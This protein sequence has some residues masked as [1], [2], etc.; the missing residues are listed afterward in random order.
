LPD[1][2]IAALSGTTIII[3]GIPTVVGDFNAATISITDAAGAVASST[4][5]ININA[6]PTI[7]ALTTT[8]WTVGKSGFTGTMTVNNGT[9]PTTIVGN[10]VGLP[11]G[12]TVQLVGNTLSFTG[13]P[14]EAGKYNGVVTIMDA[15]GATVSRSFT[16]TINPS[17]TFSKTAL[18]TYIVNDAY[19]QTVTA[20]GGT[21]KLK[22]SITFSKPLPPGLKLQLSPNGT[23]YTISGIPKALASITITIRAIDSVGAE[24][25]M[26]YT[27]TGAQNPRRRA[28]N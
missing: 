12:V 5:D 3:S 2:L 14:T 4:Y 15:A 9:L 17:I 16:I 11:T 6:A 21:G 7:T 22:L 18:P 10:P 20:R 24:T 26:I 25:V 23:S 19:S 8:A 13:T 27:L 1:G 28:Q